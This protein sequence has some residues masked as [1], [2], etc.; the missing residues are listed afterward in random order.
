MFSKYYQSE[1]T[2]LR[3]LGAFFGKANPTIASLL[4]ERSTDPDVERLLEGFAFLSAR[5]RERIDDA[6]PE[7]VQA[8]A[9]LLFP[10]YLR[11]LPAATILE[12][13]PELGALRGRHTLPRGTQVASV[14]VE[15]TSCVFRTT[16]DTDLLPL[17][18]EDVILDQSS[19]TSP[20]LRL[21]FECA[22]KALPTVFEPGGIRLFLSGDHAGSS[23]LLLWL[24]RYCTGVQVA[25]LS[26]PGPTVTLPADVIQASGFPAETSLI[27]W[28]EFSRPGFRMLLEYFTLPAKFLFVD[29]T[30]LHEAA[31]AA[32]ERF[33]LAFRFDK[34]PQL[35]TQLGRQSV[36]LHC[37]PAVNLFEGTANPIRR[38]LI[39]HEHLL[40]AAD[41]DPAHMDIYAVRSVTGIRAEH[42]ERLSYVPFVAF[43][44]AEADDDAAFYRLRQVAS[45]IDGGV[46]TYF[47]LV[48]PRD[49][50]PDMVEE[51]FSIEVTCTNRF[52]GGELR[53]GD[54]SQA[55]VGSPAVATFRNIT[56]VTKPVRPPLGEELYWR[57]IAHLSLNHASLARSDS[58]AALV[59][60]YNFHDQANLASGRANRMRAEA[61]RAVETV[62]GWRLVGGAPVRGAET[63]VELQ[64]E[65]FASEGDA[66]LFGC[67]LDDLLADHISLNAFN[68][69]VVRLEPS[70][71][72]YQWP[73][74]AGAKTL[75]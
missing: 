16:A 38:S 57:L 42:T 71:G 59:G 2:Y 39:E 33:E 15:G 52:L 69:L 34:P 21:R 44:H 60:L 51:T 13:S 75:L 8:L 63:H 3:D 53:P 41:V 66:F 67:V 14:P 55:T 19:A 12:F 73:A 74:R 43:S 46:D 1:L 32:Q 7:I 70:Q 29:V 31:A 50:K 22:E 17:A 9:E 10:H 64:E 25:G 28:P 20:I 26:S 5:T 58:L 4:A 37:T 36:R 61:I 18:L 68:Q 54:V 45:P 27:P 6:I 72:E 11:S 23:V 24:L 40:T 30:Q 49:R 48:T 65:K 47:S 56:A 62:P 35:T